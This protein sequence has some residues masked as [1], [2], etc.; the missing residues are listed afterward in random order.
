MAKTITDTVCRE[1]KHS[2]TAQ[3]ESRE[4]G[5]FAGN[6]FMPSTE[7]LTRGKSFHRAT[8]SR[9]PHSFVADRAVET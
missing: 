9:P 8:D 6:A 3:S 2:S 7:V 4:H 5:V 1:L